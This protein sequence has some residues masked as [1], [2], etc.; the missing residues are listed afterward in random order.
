MNDKTN[1]K[2]HETQYSLYIRAVCSNLSV[3]LKRERKNWLKLLDTAGPKSTYS[4]ITRVSPLSIAL[5]PIKLKSVRE[6]QLL[7]YK[8]HCACVR[9]RG[10]NGTVKYNY[11]SIYIQY[12]IIHC[13]FVYNRYFIFAYILIINYITNLKWT[14]LNMNEL[15]D[16]WNWK[17]PLLQWLGWFNYS[18]SA[19]HEVLE[20]IGRPCTYRIQMNG[21]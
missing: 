3:L 17:C 1:A 20:P 10:G 2:N 4:Y 8:Q 21:W 6:W 12:N 5:W 15:F 16:R 13:T 11:S 7:N 9:E 18:Y 14:A 19:R